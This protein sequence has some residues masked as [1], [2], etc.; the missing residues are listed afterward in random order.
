MIGNIITIIIVI[1]AMV[2]GLLIGMSIG[3]EDEL[4]S[5]PMIGSLDFNLADPSKEFLTLHITEDIDIHK[6]PLNVLMKVNV[7]ERTNV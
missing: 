4:K 2:A 3:R 1:A 7:I 6:P 5:A